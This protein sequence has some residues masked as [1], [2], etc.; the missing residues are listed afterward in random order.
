MRTPTTATPTSLPLVQ[1]LFVSLTV[2]REETIAD[3]CSQRSATKFG[4]ALSALPRAG[5]LIH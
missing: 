2:V 3:R 5:N 4:R 1:K